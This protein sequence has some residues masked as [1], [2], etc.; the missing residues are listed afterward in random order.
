MPMI[1]GTIIVVL[2][3]FFVTFGL[4]FLASAILKSSISGSVTSLTLT[5]P[6]ATVFM[7]YFFHF[8][9]IL[10][11]MQAKTFKKLIDEDKPKWEKSEK[12]DKKFKTVTKAIYAVIIAACL[13]FPAIYMN[14][15]TTVNEDN[16]TEK[17]IFTKT[18]YDLDD[19]TS[20]RLGMN[21]TGLVFY[22]NMYSGERF[23]ILQSD[24]IY[25]DGFYERFESEYEFVAHLAEKFDAN[26]KIIQGKVTNVG[27]IIVNY[28]EVPEI[29]NH[30]SKIV[31]K[32]S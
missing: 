21:D 20:Y 11:T 17:I 16:I 30:I 15:Y 27:D 12:G 4:A 10:F 24:S 1:I 32:H 2:S 7:V 9:G 25:S 18:E 5:I 23:E 6:S 14:C 19:I 3:A 31:E 26:E 13:I 29:W 28:S 8:E 22:I